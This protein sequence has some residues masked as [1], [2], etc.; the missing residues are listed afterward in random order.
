MRLLVAVFAGFVIAAGLAFPVLHAAAEQGGAKVSVWSGVYTTAQSKR[1][2]EL[3]EGA[4]GQCHGLRLD[5]GGQADMPPSPAIA[6]DSFLFKWK[7]KTVAELFTY[8]R[9]Q[10]PTDNPGSLSDQE[11]AD[12]IAYMFAYSE[13]PAGPKELPPDPKALANIMIEMKPKK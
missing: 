7:G 8:V 6:R 5:G 2:E 3:Y 4:C 10:M 13:I 9:T 1:G 11:S 12:A